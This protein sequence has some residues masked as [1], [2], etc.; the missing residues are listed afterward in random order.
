[1]IRKLFLASI[2]VVIGCS[3]KSNEVP[4]KGSSANAP[5]ATSSNGPDCDK[6]F[7]QAKYPD[8]FKACKECEKHRGMGTMEPE[9]KNAIAKPWK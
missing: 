4:G 5:P 3:S 1:M 2:L 7:D 8:A 6:D 9:C